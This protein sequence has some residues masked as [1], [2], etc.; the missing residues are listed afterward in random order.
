[1]LKRQMQVPGAGA[2]ALVRVTLG[3]EEPAL[4][5]IFQ[6]TTCTKSSGSSS[7][8]PDGFHHM[9]AHYDPRF[10][11]MGKGRVEVIT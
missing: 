9:L 2:S 1:M 8:A 4:A 6:L 11:H 5:H 3:A 7:G 10:D